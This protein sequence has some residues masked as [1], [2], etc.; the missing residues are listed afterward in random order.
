MAFAPALP[1]WPDLLTKAFC[2][3]PARPGCG[4]RSL[5]GDKASEGKGDGEAQ[6]SEVEQMVKANTGLCGVW[7]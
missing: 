6:P 4:G 2:V 5:V 7:F 1:L 3:R